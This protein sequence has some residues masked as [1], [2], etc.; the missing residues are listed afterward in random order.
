ME[1]TAPAPDPSGYDMP[2]AARRM[3][4]SMDRAIGMAEDLPEPIEA[5]VG[6]ELPPRTSGPPPDIVVGDH[7]C[8]V[9]I[10]SASLPPAPAIFAAGPSGALL[11]VRI[12]AAMPMVGEF[13]KPGEM[14]LIPPRSSCYQVEAVHCVATVEDW[15]GRV[16]NRVVVEAVQVPQAD[17]PEPG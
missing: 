5:W 10:V 11:R 13:E 17:S 16:W 9:G 1:A 14:E 15:Q 3:I 2:A 8:L 4:E 12:H 7:V 6:L